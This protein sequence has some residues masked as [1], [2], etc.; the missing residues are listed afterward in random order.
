MDHR[1]ARN[2]QSAGEDDDEHM[3]IPGG[4]LCGL[5]VSKKGL[6]DQT[7]VNY[8]AEMVS[9]D[10]ILT[11]LNYLL[12]N[13]YFWHTQDGCPYENSTAH[14]ELRNR[15]Q[16]QAQEEFQQSIPVFQSDGRLDVFFR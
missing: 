6:L 9:C 4:G 12:L 13:D 5:T 16:S 2:E 8:R 14:S 11:T 1:R 7:F 15:D 3:Q 10:P